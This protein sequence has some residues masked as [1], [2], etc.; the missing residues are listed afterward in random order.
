MT[1]LL[2][3]AVF[4]SRVHDFLHHFLWYHLTYFSIFNNAAWY[5]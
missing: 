2:T 1:T 5:K 3:Q 4:I